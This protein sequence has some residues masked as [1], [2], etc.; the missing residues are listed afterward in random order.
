MPTIGEIAKALGAEAVGRLDLEVTGAAEPAAAGPGDLALALAP[1]WAASLAQGR[2]SAALLWPD[3][4]WQSMGLKAAILAP[5]GR[6]AMARLTRMLDEDPYPAGVH[7]SAQVDPTT[8]L[9]EGVAV[10]ALTVIG[11][12]AQI[13]AGTRIG[14][15]VT[16][17]PGA[18]IGDGALIH[19]GVRI[20][21]R[22]S[23]G[24]RVI[25][26]PN[27]VIGGDGFSFVTA[28]PSHVEV[29]RDSLG[30][31]EVTIPTDPSWHR[32][33]S[34]GG[35]DIG[36]DVEVGAGATI[37]AG[38][39][40]P[41]RVGSGTKIDNLVM[42]AH[43]V[44]VGQH[45]LLCGQV[46]IAGSTVIGDRVVL[47][48]QAGVGDNLVIGNDV[49]VTGAASILSNVPAGRVM[50]GNPATR[51]DLQIE[52]YKALRRLPRIL[53]DLAAGVPKRRQDG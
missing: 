7:P 46:G 43:N 6:L 3:A 42:V 4:D 19:S 45:C 18:R 2:A 12:D 34:L 48:G 35:V 15:Q 51:M 1:N 29:A 37:D 36:D 50:M 44:V 47:G 33:H 17:A 38:T 40:R 23:I 53:R 11:A 30:R 21:R 13:G 8:R 49:V 31:G 20:G 5:R 25:L 14:P 32:I 22:V 26:Q 10:G 16:I 24:A 52:S 27:A 28:E 41:T 9:G 39:I